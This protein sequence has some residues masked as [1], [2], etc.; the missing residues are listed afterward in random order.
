[1][2]IAREKSVTNRWRSI[3]WARYASEVT[4][5]PPRD[6]PLNVGS[7]QRQQLSENGHKELCSTRIKPRGIQ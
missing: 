1:M 7:D 4:A 6:D 3:M 5:A 2:A